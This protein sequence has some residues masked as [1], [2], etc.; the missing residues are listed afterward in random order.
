MLKSSI[1][2]ISDEQRK[3]YGL[4]FHPEDKEMS[5]PVLDNFIRM[6]T[7]GVDEQEKLKMGQFEHLL[8]FKNF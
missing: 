1:V 4:L 2:G 6:C 8:N 3:R 7:G 5:Y